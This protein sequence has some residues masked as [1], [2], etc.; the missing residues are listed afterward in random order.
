MG[1][2]F[3]LSGQVILITGAGR[4]LGRQLA[5]G[6]AA[7]GASVALFDIDGA[8]LDEAAAACGGDGHI[9]DVADPD[10]FA[11]AA[12]QV[13]ARHG[14]IDAVVNNAML[15]RYD[16]LDRIEDAVMQRMIAIGMGGAVSGARALVRHMDQQRG[17]SI[18]NLTSPVG[19]RGFAGTLVYAMVKGALASMTRTLAVELGPRGVRVNAVAPGSIPTPGAVALTPREEYERRAANIP[20]RRLGTEKDATAAMLFLLS[21]AA[22]F[23]T[24]EILHVDGGISAKG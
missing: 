4:G 23:V 13:A 8:T 9:V 24:G 7:A 6:A 21:D 2:G 1:D 5:I 18:L 22:R 12:A 16:P 10:A 15:I 20:L 11:A 19:E 14:R 17:G 3:D